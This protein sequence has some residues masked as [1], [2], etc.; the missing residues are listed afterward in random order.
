MTSAICHFVN[1]SLFGLFYVLFS[2]AFNQYYHYLNVCL[3]V[4]S[5]MVTEL[6]VA[7]LSFCMQQF[8]EAHLLCYLVYGDEE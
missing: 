6:C 4:P 7:G 8:H 1:C 2:I 5:C 3:L